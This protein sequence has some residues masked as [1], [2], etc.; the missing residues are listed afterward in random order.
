MSVPTLT[1]LGRR[2]LGHLP[3]WVK[4]EKAHIKAEGGAAVS[5][6]SYSLADF[7]SR[8]AEDPSTFVVDD[9]GPRSLTEAEC[10][11]S[12]AALADQGLAE[13]TDGE[14]RMTQLGFEAI[15]APVEPATNAPDEVVV[16]LNAAVSQSEA[17]GG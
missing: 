7:T 15:T 5:V 11:T 12:L 10:G 2:V 3:V 4:N 17:F 14:W 16:P 9:N 1:A 13:E 8:L 6:R